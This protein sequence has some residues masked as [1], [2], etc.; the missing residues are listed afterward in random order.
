MDL[1]LDSQFMI[2]K[3]THDMNIYFRR[4]LVDDYLEFIHFKMTPIDE[5]F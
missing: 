2:F 5:R 1:D 3:I 4:K